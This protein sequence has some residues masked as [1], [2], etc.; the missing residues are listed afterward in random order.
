MVEEDP[1]VGEK[2]VA[3]TVVSDHPVGVDFGGAVGAARVDGRDFILGR[4]RRPEHFAARG[5]VN[6][7]FTPLRRRASR[8]RVVPRAVTSPVYSGRSKLTRTWLWA[9][10]W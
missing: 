8:M 10:R 9:P 7:A 1:V 2:T 4:G 3:L 5:L 6:L